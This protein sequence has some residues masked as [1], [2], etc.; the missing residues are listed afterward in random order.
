[1]VKSTERSLIDAE[2]ASWLSRL[3]SSRKSAQT[4]SAFRAWLSTSETHREA[5]E[6][7]TEVWDMLPS[8]SGDYSVRVSARSRSHRQSVAL[9]ASVALILGVLSLWWATRPPLYETRVGEERVVML[10]DH[11]RVALNTNSELEINYSRAERRVV[12]DHGEA[13]FEVSKDPSRPCFVF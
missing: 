11:S 8:V 4:E 7:A 13:L 2:A 3:H 9:A 5:F 12:L 6:R 1:M 10:S